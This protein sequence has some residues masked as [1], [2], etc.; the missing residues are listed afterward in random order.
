MKKSEIRKTVLRLAEEHGLFKCVQCGKCSSICTM[1][2]I[3]P[4]FKYSW[5]PR[6]VIRDALLAPDLL[7]GRAIWYCLTCEVC[8]FTCPSGVHFRDFVTSLRTLAIEKGFRDYSGHC[9]SCGRPL[10]PAHTLKHV[11]GRL[12]G[13]AQNPAHLC[14]RCKKRIIVGRFKDDTRADRKVVTA[15]PRNGRRT[16]GR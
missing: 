6:T 15:W 2:D 11:K 8:E 1:V 10:L 5:A 9:R 4:D 3:F 16:S 12:E 13:Y 14:E 7:G